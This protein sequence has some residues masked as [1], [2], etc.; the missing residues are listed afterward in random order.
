MTLHYI[1]GETKS[2]QGSEFGTIQR[3]ER[4][5][6]FLGT[7]RQNS[8]LSRK[9]RPG[10]MVTLRMLDL[11]ID[12]GLRFAQ[13]TRLCCV[14]DTHSVSGSSARNSPATASYELSSLSSS[15]VSRSDD[16]RATRKDYL[17][18]VAD[19]HTRLTSDTSVK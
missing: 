4:P 8:G 16:A 1:Q 6:N 2:G 10:R 19:V 3:P 17:S 18:A 7:G 9:N 11:W 5:R 14:S 15:V 12:D 13:S